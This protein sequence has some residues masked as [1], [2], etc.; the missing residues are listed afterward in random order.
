M[1]QEIKTIPPLQIGD[2]KEE[3]KL[4]VKTWFKSLTDWFIG[5]TIRW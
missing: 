1:E 3:P 4:S 2:G 5:V